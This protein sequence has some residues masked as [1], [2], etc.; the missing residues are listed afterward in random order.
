MTKITR[1][2]LMT[3]FRRGVVDG[4]MVMLQKWVMSYQKVEYVTRIRY[5]DSAKYRQQTI[6]FDL[7][8]V[9]KFYEKKTDG[10]FTKLY[11]TRIKKLKELRC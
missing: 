10:R 11:A 8:E 5:G 9:I 7:E 6:Y 2:D 3:K 4:M 1:A